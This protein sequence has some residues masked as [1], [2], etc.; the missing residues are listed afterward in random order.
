MHARLGYDP[1]GD[2]YKVLCVVIFDGHERDTTAEIKQEHHVYSLGSHSGWREAQITTEKS[3]TDVEG[4]ICI[5]GAIYYGVGPT[6]IA[7]FDLRYE[8]VTFIEA[9]KDYYTS[10]SLINHQGKL[11]GMQYDNYLYEL[12]V[13]IQE[14]Q[15]LWNK[16]SCV[17]PCEWRDLYKDKRP[18]SPGEIHTGEVM[19]VSD[20]LQSSRP[21]SVFYCDV[22]QESF[23]SAQVKGIA[24]YE[25]RRTHG[26]G[27]HDLDML[28]FPGYTE[29][30]MSLW[31]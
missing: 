19:F 30:I 24:D 13:W 31:P 28:C 20:R 17:A 14:K 2:E 9:P 27:M 10:W 5:N 11:G 21:F 4:G 26:I 6:K 7:R 3:Y 23:R 29:N 12:R 1:V 15:K 25:F 8:K 16:M 18:S 22:I